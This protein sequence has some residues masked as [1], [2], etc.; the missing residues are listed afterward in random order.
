MSQERTEQGHFE[1]PSDRG[2]EGQ[3]EIGVTRDTWTCNDC[4]FEMNAEHYNADSP[5]GCREYDCPVC[6]NENLES[7]I[8]CL[9]ATVAELREEGKKKDTALE[10][11]QTRFGRYVDHSRDYESRLLSRIDEEVASV[12]VLTAKVQERD[13]VISSMKLTDT[14]LRDAE[15]IDLEDRDKEIERLRAVINKAAAELSHVDTFT[16]H[17]TN[18]DHFSNAQSALAAA[19]KGAE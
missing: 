9:N 8:D 2:K 17:P 7:E 13:A 4:G 18:E 10:V 14:L 1:E 3:I 15:K 11:V 6:E 16:L 5:E 12:K 19:L